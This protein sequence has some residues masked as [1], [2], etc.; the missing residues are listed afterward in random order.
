[1]T[2]R[3]DHNVTEDGEEIKF[4]I[5]IVGNLTFRQTIGP[6]MGYF[7]GNLITNTNSETKT[8]KKLLATPSATLITY[9]KIGGEHCG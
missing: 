4:L 5:Y 6:P 8:T 9:T 7:L 2:N 3:H 1:M